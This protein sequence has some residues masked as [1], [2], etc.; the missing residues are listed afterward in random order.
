MI[1]NAM[2][3]SFSS[4]SLIPCSLVCGTPRLRGCTVRARHRWKISQHDRGATAAPNSI[5][6]Q[7]IS[8]LSVFFFFEK[9]L[10]YQLRAAMQTQPSIPSNHTHVRTASSVGL[11]FFFFLCMPL[12]V[13]VVF[14]AYMGMGRPLWY[15]NGLGILHVCLV[16][17]VR[18]E[19]ISRTS[20]KSLYSLGRNRQWRINPYHFERIKI[21]KR[22][23]ELSLF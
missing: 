9:H 21:L 10:D 15:M 16:E 4:Q 14:L 8:R 17:V 3:R 2:R 6:P 13:K 5:Y 20:V 23:G 19:Y 12:Y 7:K 22:R 1:I 11:V 18:Y